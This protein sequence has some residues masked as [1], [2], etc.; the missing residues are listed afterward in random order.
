MMSQRGKRTVAIQVFANVSR[1]KGNQTME[2]GPLIEYKIRNI[3]LEKPF[4]KTW[5]RNQLQ[6]PYQKNNIGY[7]CGPIV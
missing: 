7:I 5:W 2:S 1:S 6:T 4:K 3:S